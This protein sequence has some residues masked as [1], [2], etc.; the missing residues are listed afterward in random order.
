MGTGA[1]SLRADLGP[2]KQQEL[3]FFHFTAAKKKEG[4]LR[5][6]CCQSVTLPTTDEEHEEPGISHF[7][8]ATFPVFDIEPNKSCAVGR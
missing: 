3:A 4:R 8:H 6:S 1:C 5:V 7:F 2:T